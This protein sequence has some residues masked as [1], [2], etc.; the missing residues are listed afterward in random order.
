MKASELKK[1]MLVWIPC[2]VRGGPFGNERRVYIKI[3]DSEWFG[4]VDET[5]LEKKVTHGKDRVKAVV[6]TFQSEVGLVVLGVR[7]Q[8]PASGP[9]HTDETF[10]NQYGA[11]EA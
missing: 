10:L 1:G 6:L 7:G 9:I 11:I 4:F 3:G 8:S 2:D 5:E